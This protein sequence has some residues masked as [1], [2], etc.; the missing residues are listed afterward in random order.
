[1]QRTFVPWSFFYSRQLLCCRCTK[2]L[3]GMYNK[4]VN[5]NNKDA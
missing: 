2:I 1:M 3:L 4:Y 5:N